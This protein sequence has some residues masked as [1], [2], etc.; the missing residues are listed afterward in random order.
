MAG[1]DYNDTLEIGTTYF[2]IMWEVET[3][4]EGTE[5]P[6]D[7]TGAT[8]EFQINN[9]NENPPLV[10]HTSTTANGEITLIE[11]DTKVE[12]VIPQA[13]TET[14]EAGLFNY[15]I[16]KTQGG[17]TETWLSG[18]LEIVSARIIDE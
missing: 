7:L 10:I 15:A 6:A 4:D 2:F 5:T 8:F 1:G 13:I 14:L 17:N 18:D 16:R 9:L 3:D 12:V 11:D